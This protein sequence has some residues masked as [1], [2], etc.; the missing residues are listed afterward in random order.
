[1]NVDALEPQSLIR[2]RPFVL[3]WNARIF[4]SIAAQMLSVAVGWQMYGL[5]GDPF[6]LGLVGFAQF[7]PALVLMMVAGQLADRY[8]RR[9]ILQAFLSNDGRRGRSLAGHQALFTGSLSKEF[10]LAAVFLLGI[11]RSF[12]APT[13]QTLLPAIVPTSL[14]PRAVAG[15]A[16]AQQIATIS[17]PAIGGL[18]YLASATVVYSVCCTLFLCAALQVSFLKIRHDAVSVRPPLTLNA[19]FAG[20]SFIRHNPI[21]LGVMSLDLFAVLLGGATAL[22][23]SL[24]RTCSTSDRRD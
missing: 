11:G 23:P 24:P 8:N 9:T 19:F 22:L 7:L 10:I 16:T 13:M 12:E 14:F 6:D 1:M 3:Y 15:S 2:H 4:T 20:L 17:G 5:T 21:L 18:L